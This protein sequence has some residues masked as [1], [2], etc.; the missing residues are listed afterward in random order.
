MQVF[1]WNH[2]YHVH[3][4]KYT[5]GFVVF[6]MNYALLIKWAFHSIHSLHIRTM[7]NVSLISLM[8]TYKSWTVHSILNQDTVS[9]K[10]LF[11]LCINR[12][13]S[14]YFPPSLPHIHPA[15]V[16]IPS[17]AVHPFT[18]RQQTTTTLHT[19]GLRAV[20]EDTFWGERERETRRQHNL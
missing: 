12:T 5:R 20:F 7:S 3:T 6:L 4:H 15:L 1:K 2:I 14:W 16:S 9:W 17:Y 18:L 8:A 13:E 19:R 10:L 11:L